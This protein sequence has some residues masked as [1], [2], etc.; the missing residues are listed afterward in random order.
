MKNYFDIVEKVMNDGTIS[1]N[2]TGVDTLK[3]AGALFE[4]DMSKGFP[5]LTTKKMAFKTMAVELEGF[6]KGITDKRWFQDRGCH[7]WDEWC[8]PWLVPYGHDDETRAR[9][10]AEH[11]L[12][13]I[14]GK[15]WRKFNS[16]R[17]FQGID[18]LAKLVDMLKNNPN[19]RRMLVS[20]WNPCQLDQMALPP[21]HWGFQ[22]TVTNGCINLLWNQRSVDVALGLPFNIAS[23][24]LLLLLLSIES[25]FKPGKLIGFLGDVHIY[26]NHLKGLEE[27]L[28]REPFDL[29]MVFIDW[30]GFFNFDHE[31]ALLVEYK[32][33]PKIPFEIAV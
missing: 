10:K 25:G 19:D 3:I 26:V 24:G 8:S 5:L 21:C 28:S 27:Q 7:I 20:A 6:I 15:Q 13:P 32:H 12:G 18:Q 22:V 11:E 31:N 9:M 16:S 2:R 1:H 33:H 23:Y 29:P 14:Y 4:H 30:N 17:K